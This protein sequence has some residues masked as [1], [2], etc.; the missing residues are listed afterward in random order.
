MASLPGPVFTRP[1]A[2]SR[3]NSPTTTDDKDGE[4]VSHEMRTS[5]A[6]RPESHQTRRHSVLEDVIIP[7]NILRYAN[8]A[9]EWVPTA[10][11]SSSQDRHRGDTSSDFS[12]I[13]IAL[14]QQ[15]MM[16]TAFGNPPGSQVRRSSRTK[17]IWDHGKATNRRQTSLP[18]LAEEKQKDVVGPQRR[19]TSGM[20]ATRTMSRASIDIQQE[21]N[22]P[23]VGQQ[24]EN[25]ILFRSLENYSLNEAEDFRLRRYSSAVPPD[26]DYLAVYEG[27]TEKDNNPS[28]YEDLPNAT[29][30]V[31]TKQPADSSAMRRASVAIASAYRT[32]T[33]GTTNVMRRSSLWDA[34]ENAKIRSQHLQ[35]KKWVQVVF[36]YTFYLVLACFVYFVLVGRPLWNGSVWYLYWVVH[37]KFTVAGTWSITI[38]LAIV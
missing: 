12:V 34:Y 23:P 37:T 8:I 20:H 13:N 38:A 18:T 4:Y 21:Q 11:I 9:T 27:S 15:A 29:K 22:S 25:T 14:E 7:T 32:L 36:E 1:A 24:A 10:E 30:D 16:D 35:R 5:T 31:E 6:D 26:A 2:L 33:Q 17:T 3:H 28:S 19:L